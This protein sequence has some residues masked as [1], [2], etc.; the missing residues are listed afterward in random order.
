MFSFS[1]FVSLTFFKLQLGKRCGSSPED[2]DPPARNLCTSL[3]VCGGRVRERVLS[4]T[5]VFC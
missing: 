1:I 2:V 4:H 5:F 3:G